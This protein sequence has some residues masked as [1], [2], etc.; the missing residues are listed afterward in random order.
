MTDR[1]YQWLSALRNEDADGIPSRALERLENHGW[2]KTFISGEFC[3]ITQRG[4]DA[5]DLEER[6]RNQISQQKAENAARQ[7]EEQA[8]SAKQRREDSRH[9][10]CVAILSGVT[11]SIATLIIEHFSTIIDFIEQLFKP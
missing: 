6:T 5:L 11:G 3:E 1:E 10:Y 7:Q 4:L 8:R 2:I 9:D